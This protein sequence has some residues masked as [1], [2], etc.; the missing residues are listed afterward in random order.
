MST[1][2]ALA[3]PYVKSGVCITRISGPDALKA[4]NNFT[5][6][7]GGVQPRTCYYTSIIDKRNDEVIDTGLVVYF[8]GPSSFTGE[9]VVE[10]HTHGSKAVIND[11]L[12]LLSTLDNYSLAEAGEF[13]KRAF[14]N[15]KMD[16]LQVE[17]LAD[18]IDAETKEQRKQALRQTEGHISSIYN[19]WR[20]QI[21][22]IQSYIEAFLDFPEEDIPES[23]MEDLKHQITSLSSTLHHHITDHSRGEKIRDGIVVTII[24]KANAGKSSLLNA[25][26]KRPMAIV[27]DIP[28]TTRDSIE[29]PLDIQGYLCT[30][31]DTAGLR[32]TDDAIETIGIENTLQKARHADYKIALF[33]KNDLPNLD[34]VT[35]NLVDEN[36]I[37]CISKCDDESD[38]LNID[39]IDSN[40]FDPIFLSSTNNIGMDRLIE[41][42]MDKIK[43][44][45][46]TVNAPIITRLRHRDNIT[47]AYQ[48]LSHCDVEGDLI[49]L[50]ENLR[51]VSQYL[52][53][54]VGKVGV[55]DILGRIFS[56]FCLGK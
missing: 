30:L 45:D 50:A 19:S 32:K 28:G 7:K 41:R 36:T 27:S 54:V 46:N 1:I 26:A 4:I 56:S 20:D 43:D 33:D 47:K 49:L 24:G 14:E 16:L 5:L 12:G 8:K 48:S 51:Q 34:Q 55:E 35:L 29:V 39:L 22:E 6:I 52:G 2:Y 23:V 25:L 21:I 18:L 40:S 10:F 17:G 44:Q 3:S 42:L 37:V 15:G 38:I 31:I 11:L 53:E 13:T 9:D